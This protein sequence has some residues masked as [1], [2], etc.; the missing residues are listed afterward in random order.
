VQILVDASV[1]LDYFQGKPAPETDRLHALLGQSPLLV[2]DVVLAEVLH[3]LP[4]EFHRKQAREAL[5]KFWQIEIAGFD[6]A[7][8]TAV[9][10]HTLRARGIEVDPVECRIATFCIDQ[11]FAL[12]HSSAGYGAFE[13]YLGLR[14]GGSS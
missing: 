1:W 4:D 8:K 7:E 5:T 12:L 13:R 2:A 9:N 6:L 14:V 3:T 10:Y 11:G